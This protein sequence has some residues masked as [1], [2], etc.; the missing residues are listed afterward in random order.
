MKQSN[1]FHHALAAVAAV[2]L[3][4]S[5]SVFF[6]GLAEARTLAEVKA[7]GI[8][9]MCAHPDALPYASEKGDAPGFQ[10]ELGQ[11]IAEGLGLS[12]STEWIVPRRRARIVNCDMLLDKPS[13]PKVTEGKLLLSRSYQR[14]GIALGLSRDAQ[15]I[16]DYTE[17]QKGQKVGVM[18]S[19]LASVVLGKAGKTTSPYAFQ[20]DM[21]E[22]LEK[23]ELYGIAVS[24]A[25]MSHYIATHPDSGFK[26]AYAFDSDPELSWNVSVGLRDSD[27]AMLDAV[28][29]VL[30]RLID[31][32]TVARI[33]QKYGVEHRLP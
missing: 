20:S 9:S 16:G 18:I 24:S 12:L 15:M 31:D 28:N 29:G 17:L 11:K 3:L 21:L 4:A 27:Q 22:D 30:A 14:S 19:S 10:V 32:G 26:L 25:T 6:P 23:G 1:F 8:I 7:L 33:Y 5:G 2:T 13:D